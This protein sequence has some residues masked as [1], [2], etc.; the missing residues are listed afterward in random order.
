MWNMSIAEFAASLYELFNSRTDCYAIKSVV[1][2]RK[3]YEPA[4]DLDNKDLEFTIA[5]CQAHLLGDISI[6]CYPL[7]KQDL[8]KWVSLDFDGKRGNALTDAVLV[9][10]N[11]ER[12]LGLFTWLERS[13]SGNGVHL[14]IFFSEKLSARVVRAVLS[15]YIPEFTTPVERR[16][17]SFDRM[18]P[19]QDSAFGSYGN[20]CALP[21]NGKAA[22]KNGK[23]AFISETGET[24]DSNKILQE[25]LTK[26]NVIETVVNT[27]KTIKIGPVK[28]NLPVLAQIPGGTKLLCPAGCA[29]LRK[30]LKN[31]PNLSEPEWYAALGQFGRVEQGDLLAHKFSEQYSGYT[32]DET[33]KK[34]EHAKVA[35]AMSC[36]TIWERFGDCGKRCSPLGV[37]APWE[38]A[39][40]PL[41][42][43]E[44]DNKGKIHDAKD[45]AKIA[46]QV[47]DETTSGK[48]IGF[49]WGYNWL[50]DV[51]ELRPRNLVVVAARQGIGKTAILIDASIRGAE[52]GVPQYIFSIEMGYEELAIRYAARLTEIDHSLIATGKI[53]AAEYKHVLQALDH[54][55]TLPIFVDD[56]T[57]DQDRMLDNAGELIYKNG[58]GIIWVDYLQLVRKQNKESKKDAVDRVVDGYKQMAKIL[59][60]PVVTLAQLNRTEETT[61]SSDDLDSW[62]KDSG[63]IEQTADV[64]HYIRGRRGPGLIDR[65]WRVHKE[66]HRASGINLRFLFNQGIFKFDPQ[67]YWDNVDNGQFQTPTNTNEL[68]F[69]EN[70]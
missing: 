45:I 31:G 64:I 4:R 32:Y 58:T 56:S 16:S 34:Y 14:W 8:V 43:L 49:A 35:P 53:S 23:T 1:E 36:E 54:F 67:G 62:L 28:K 22:V 20:L 12:E 6:G 68:I 37:K 19:N 7:D 59:D 44:Q 3:I 9:K 39:K 11:I 48:R 57:R 50:D 17:T 60:A 26:R 63:D 52:R 21:L 66:R 40:V 46:K 13:Q 41:A 47:L 33:Q 55:K 27:A 61:E 42:K 15:Q 10:K 5:V 30:C 70:Q 18:F 38:L 29:W 65:R 25:I 24:L 2:G 51:T 69:T